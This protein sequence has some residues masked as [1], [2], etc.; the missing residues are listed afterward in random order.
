MTQTS[1]SKVVAIKK[2][3]NLKILLSIFILGLAGICIFF[4][5]FFTNQ[6]MKQTA[7]A[8]Q[9]L[10]SLTALEAGTQSL[11]EFARQHQADLAVI[12]TLFP[13]ED[14][15]IFAFQDLEQL[16]IKVDPK[17]TV[18]LG[19]SVP[20]KVNQQNT[21]PLSIHFNAD[22]TQILN[23]LRQ[24]EHL[25]YILEI[26]SLEVTTPP[27]GGNLRDVIISVKL[28]VAEPFNR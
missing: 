11:Q 3:T 24:F 4:F 23:F 8:Q 5:S 1:D 22:Q 28:Y 15:F 19:A 12:N 17:A 21:L 20:T 16:V 2:Q 18:K 10:S 25:P 6:K 13:N 26:T 7:T 27:E 9:E 14:D